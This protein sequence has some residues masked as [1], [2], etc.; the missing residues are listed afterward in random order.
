MA[1]TRFYTFAERQTHTQRSRRTAKDVERRGE[2]TASELKRAGHMG[3]LSCAGFVGVI[4]DQARKTTKG[5]LALFLHCA[6]AST[7]ITPD[8]KWRKAFALSEIFYGSAIAY[9]SCQ[10]MSTPKQRQTIWGAASLNRQ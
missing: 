7:V 2:A 6:V 8:L 1:E 10:L 4:E 3:R 9:K 5:N